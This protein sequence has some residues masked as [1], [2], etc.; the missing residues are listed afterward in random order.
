M[1]LHIKKGDLVEIITGDQKGSTGKVLR[2]IPHKNRVIVQG[3]NLAKKHV[4]PSRKNPQGGRLNIEQPINISNVLPVN[5]KNSK[6]TRIS[7]KIQK[8]GSKER[9]AEDGSVISIVKKAK[10]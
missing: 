1:A 8:D 4:K 9:V 7:Y 2:V 3:Q 6:A 5:P 10:K